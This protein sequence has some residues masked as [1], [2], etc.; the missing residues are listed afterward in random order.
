MNMNVDFYNPM[1]RILN[2]THVDLDGAVSAIVIKNY[3]NDVIVEKTN[4]G[5]EQQIY[6]SVL[7][8]Q[9]QIDAIIFTDFTPVNL[10][11]IQDLGKPVLLLDHHESASKFND[12][13]NNIYISSKY[14][15]AMLAW[16]FFSIKKDLSFLEELVKLTNDF[17]MFILK[18]KRSLPFNELFWDMGFHWFIRRF[19]NGN[20]T[21]YKEEK[22]FI[23]DYIEDFKKKYDELP[24]SNLP[25]GGCFYKCEKYIAEMSHRLALDGYKYQIIYYRNNLSLRSVEGI[26]LTLVCNQIG[27]GGG[28]KQSAGITLAPSDDIKDLVNRICLAIEQVSNYDGDLPF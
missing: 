14:C 9:N 15:G 12:P 20:T 19:K 18:D 1:L 26:D 2:F 13:R 24:L 6:D 8:H 27:R 3:Y 11:Q 25:N 4:Y 16:K 23:L 22:D 5:K 28:H 10:K 21:L 17:D 7:K